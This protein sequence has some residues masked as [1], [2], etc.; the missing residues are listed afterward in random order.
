MVN[1]IA[2]LPKLE[3][4]SIPCFTDFLEFLIYLLNGKVTKKMINVV[5]LQSLIMN[6]QPIN[7]F[8]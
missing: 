3:Q 2:D 1:I 8:P 7:I 5:L 6:K 4:S